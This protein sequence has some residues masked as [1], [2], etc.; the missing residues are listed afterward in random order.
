MFL[1]CLV[2]AET[3]RQD[4]RVLGSVDS[5]TQP[6]EPRRVLK[7]RLTL[8]AGANG[9]KRLVER[10]GD[11]LICVR[12]RYD[13][14]RRVRMKTVELIEEEAPWL[15]PDA[16]YLVKIDWEETELQVRVKTAGAT[17]DRQRRRWRMSPEL[18]RALNLLPR[19][20][21]IVDG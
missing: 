17:W 11:R 19:V 14:E 15:P 6:R 9:T 8:P 3:R 2:R 12:Y 5:A 7:T 4:S 13:R 20:T 21:G 18:V 10:Y 16:L 1:R